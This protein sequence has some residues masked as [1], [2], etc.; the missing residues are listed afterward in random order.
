[1]EK[2][3]DFPERMVSF[4]GFAFVTGFLLGLLAVVAAEVAAF[5]YLVKRLNRKRNLQ[6]SKSSDPTLKGSDPPPPNSID[7]NLN[8]QVIDQF[9]PPE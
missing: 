7:F 1:M 9:Q 4:A 5:L 3:I 8:K 2:A 6:E